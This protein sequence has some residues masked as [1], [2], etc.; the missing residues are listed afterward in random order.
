MAKS[1]VPLELPADPT[2]PLESATKRYVDLRRVVPA[3][4]TVG[5]AAS[6]TID[7]TARPGLIRIN[8]ATGNFTIAALSNGIDAQMAMIEVTA[9]ADL[10]LTM[11]TSFEL[12]DLVRTRTV[13]I[14]SG[15]TAL[16]QAMARTT[17]GGLVW[18]LLSVDNGG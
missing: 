4:A 7:V 6:L 13:P 9:T 12:G 2:L 17:S 10:T 16:I 5:W 14:R 15:V 3:V 8:P 18:R 11:G 1:R